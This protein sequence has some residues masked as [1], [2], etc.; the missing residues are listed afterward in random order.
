MNKIMASINSLKCYT[1]FGVL[2]K[3]L[4]S[5]RSCQHQLQISIQNSIIKTK[6]DE[7]PNDY[8]VMMGSGA[9]IYRYLKSRWSKSIVDI[10]YLENYFARKLSTRLLS[11]SISNYISSWKMSPRATFLKYDKK[12][13]AIPL[14]Y[15][16][17]FCGSHLSISQRE[18]SILNQNY[19]CKH[20]FTSSAITN[21]E[22]AESIKP[23]IFQKLYKS[24]MPERLSVSKHK[25]H[26]SGLT[27]SACC[28][29]EVDFEA[30]IKVFD[31]PDTYYSW[32]LV[33]EIHAW[34]M[35]VRLAVGNT[36]EGKHCRNFMVKQLYEEMDERAKK[37]AEMDRKS[38]LNTVWDLAEEFKLAM[39]IYDLGLAGS[40]IDLANSVWRRF[41]L[42]I[43]NP[44][45]EK[46]ELLVKYIRKT[47]ASMDRIKLEDLFL[48]EPDSAIKWP[49]VNKLESDS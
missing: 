21:S 48:M 35:C 37:V 2:K 47:V 36:P 33:T 42:G 7:K 31:M 25:L 26:I 18:L 20:H 8:F 19:V 28:S 24:L 23:N 14:T 30:F 11:S 5:H 22:T 9:T 16:K 38:R 10:S 46:I 17:V 45:V 40:D 43:E 44:D 32:W 39:I 12:T 27:L 3:I 41:F 4:S 6:P 34:M 1:N 49:D 13:S 29:H 15:S